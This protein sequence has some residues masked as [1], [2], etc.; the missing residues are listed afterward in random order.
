MHPGVATAPLDQLQNLILILGFACGA[1]ILAA[2]VV[3][4]MDAK[5]D[6]GCPSCAHC[7]DRLRVRADAQRAAQEEYERRFGLRVLDDEEESRPSPKD[8]RPPRDPDGP[9]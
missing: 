3:W 9:G 6:R 2:A 1:L 7:K 5:I 4:W 8:D